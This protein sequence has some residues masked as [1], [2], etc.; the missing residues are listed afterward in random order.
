MTAIGGY[1][2]GVILVEMETEMGMEGRGWPAKLY[3]A[4]GQLFGA[5]DTVL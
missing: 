3:E 1:I 2:V 4:L 5:E